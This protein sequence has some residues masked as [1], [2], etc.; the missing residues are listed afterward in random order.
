MEFVHLHLH[1]EYS[2]LD[3]ACRLSLLPKALPLWH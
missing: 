3:G 1:S 2:M